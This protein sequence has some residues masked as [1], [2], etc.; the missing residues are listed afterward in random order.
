[1]G[2]FAHM[3]GDSSVLFI[4]QRVGDVTLSIS[5]LTVLLVLICPINT[6][7]MCNLIASYLS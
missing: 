7:S 1:M 2:L 3:F 4:S 6:T 5:L